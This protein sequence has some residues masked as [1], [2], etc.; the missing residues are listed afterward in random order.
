MNLLSEMDEIRVEY[1]RASAEKDVLHMRTQANQE[2]LENIDQRVEQLIRRC[3]TH[4]ILNDLRD[5]HI[6][7]EDAYT[8]L[9]E[10]R[11]RTEIHRSVCMSRPHGISSTG[12]FELFNSKD[13]WVCQYDACAK[14]I[15]AFRVIST[16]FEVTWEYAVPVYPKRMHV[17][18]I[19]TDDDAQCSGVLLVFGHEDGHRLLLGRHVFNQGCSADVI[20]DGSCCAKYSVQ[21]KDWKH[22][23]WMAQL[24]FETL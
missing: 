7:I 8:L 1:A 12:E 6:D 14:S 15:P 21:G 4:H 17:N 10:E 5:N 20:C 19:S 23:G 24:Q 22:S 16:Q 13:K 11:V 9:D 18:I 2:T 3:N